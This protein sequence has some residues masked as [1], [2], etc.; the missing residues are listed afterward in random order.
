VALHQVFF[1][2]DQFFVLALVFVFISGQAKEFLIDWTP[3][4]LLILTYEYFRGLIPLVNH[5]IHFNLM[6]RFD[7]LVFKQIPSVVLQRLFY[8]PGHAHWYDYVAV[9]LYLSHFIIPLITGFIFWE[10]DRA[11]YREF[12]I[13]IVGLSYLTFLTYLI[14]PAAPPWL[15]AQQG[16]IP[17][18][19]HVTNLLLGHLFSYIPIFTVYRYVGVNLTAAVPSLHAAYPLLTALYIGKKFKRAIPI[20]VIYVLAIWVAVMY[21]G[22][23]YFFDVVLGA[24]YAAFIYVVIQRAKK[25]L[26]RRKAATAE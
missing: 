13:A 2:P 11:Y 9:I 21:L 26:I 20:L 3:L 18:V 23:H 25:Y 22:E 17:P 15:A 16:I 19:V 7:Q 8:S 10:I 14:F 6:W 24:I 1:T 5:H 12:A 4:V